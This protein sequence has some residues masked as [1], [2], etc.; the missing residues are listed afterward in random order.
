MPLNLPEHGLSLY[1]IP[2]N[3]STT[4]WMWGFLLRTGE[5]CQKDLYEN[6]WMYDGPVESKTMMVRRDPVARFI[7][8]YRNSRDK[9]GLAMGF[10]EF[11]DRLPELMEEDGEIAH[12]FKAQE[13]YFPEK[14]LREV[15]YVFDFDDFGAVRA[16]LEERTKVEL[17]DYHEQKSYFDDFTVSGEEIEKIKNY[18]LDDYIEGFGELFDRRVEAGAARLVTTAVIGKLDYARKTIPWMRKYAKMIGADFRMKTEFGN[19]GED[20]NCSFYVAVDL[21]RE[22]SDQSHYEELLFLDADVLVSPGA[23][24]IFAE[25]GAGQLGLARDLCHTTQE[26][27]FKGWLEKNGESMKWYTLDGPYFNSGVIALRLDG[28]RA[29]NFDGPYPS[30]PWYDQDWLNLRIIQSGMEVSILDRKWNCWPEGEVVGD[31]REAEFLHFVGPRKGRIDHYVARLEKDHREPEPIE[32]REDRRFVI[33]C[34]SPGSPTQR[35]KQ[36]LE[37][38][39]TVTIVSDEASGEEGVIHIPDAWMS[40]FELMNFS[41]CQPKAV[42][43]QL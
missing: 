33:L 28:A 41:E 20:G 9:R 43:R 6:G 38:F 1:P 16:F 5:E 40:G 12:H 26:G 4:L 23:R 22:F 21:L 11:V 8:G 18:Y 13:A 39:G 34:R 14:P 27:H 3:G 30:C 19:Q 42:E 37:K 25:L 2:K 35:L 15:D 31:L 32:C 36:I 24:D 10:P 7:S 17:P 29:L